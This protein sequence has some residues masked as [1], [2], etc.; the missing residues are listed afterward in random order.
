MG[1]NTDKEEAIKVL[2][3]LGLDEENAKALVGRIGEFVDQDVENGHEGG[4][5]GD[6]FEERNAPPT[7]ILGGD[8]GKVDLVNFL[9]KT[10]RK[11]D[12]LEKHI[13]SSEIP[14]PMMMDI[15]M[16]L[17][18]DEITRPGFKGSPVPAFFDIFATCM[19]ALN[20]KGRGEAR[21]IYQSGMEMK[22][23][24]EG[25]DKRFRV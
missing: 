22:E 13:E 4:H 2:G 14:A 7:L 17:T 15:V 3:K 21:A 16:S 25:D 12:G 11:K 9:F 10:N 20:R 19:K 8:K 1:K 18:L 23:E 6:G 24:Q 5:D